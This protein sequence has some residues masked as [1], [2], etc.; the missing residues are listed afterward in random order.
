MTTPVLLPPDQLSNVAPLFRQAPGQHLILESILAGVTPAS[1][2]VDD[3]AQPAAAMAVFQ[4]KLFVTGS[5]PNTAFSRELA[6]LLACEI[7]PAAKRTG[8]E[9]L[10]IYP[11][12]TNW[13]KE[14]LGFLQGAFP[15]FYAD[16]AR[17]Y[18]A[19]DVGQNTLP[20]GWREMLP[21]GYRLRP[22]DAALLDDHHWQHIDYL[23]EETQSERTSVADFLA[24]SFGVALTHENSLAAWCL[25]EYNCADRCEVGIATV[26]EY[27]RRGLGTVV[28]C[29][30][31]AE[32]IRRGYRQIGW[33]C[34]LRN[35]PS[36]ALAEKI[37]YS[38]RSA[39]EIAIGLF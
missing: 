27:Q 6:D 14:N 30:F 12:A 37:G 11:L 2:W 19:F 20:R 18:Y 32:A 24:H 4:N 31:V 22:V 35:R 10:L 29:S 9:A 13:V 7:I 23:R 28:G 26:E 34:W 21:A 3:A 1:V 36:A 38:L 5:S 8:M 17:Q 25:S 15:Q 39:E 16:A 33:H